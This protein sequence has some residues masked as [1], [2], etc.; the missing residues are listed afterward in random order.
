MT[1]MKTSEGV[2]SLIR[3]HKFAI[4]GTERFSAVIT[5]TRYWSYSVA[6]DSGGTLTSYLGVF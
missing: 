3:V 1:L 6:L 4:Q 2:T 5:S